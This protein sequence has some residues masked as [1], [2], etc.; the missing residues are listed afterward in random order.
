MLKTP[1]LCG[2][3]AVRCGVAGRIVNYPKQA[4]RYE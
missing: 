1:Y 4:L 2:D 3:D